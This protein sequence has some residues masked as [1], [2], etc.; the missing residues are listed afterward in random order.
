MCHTICQRDRA[1]FYH[2]ILRLTRPHPCV[3]EA[4]RLLRP[5]HLRLHEQVRRWVSITMPKCRRDPGDFNLDITVNQH[6]ENVC[7]AVIF[8][9]EFQKHLKILKR[10]PT[11]SNKNKNPHESSWKNNQKVIQEK[12]FT[13]DPTL[14][15][16]PLF[17]CP[18][19]GRPSQSSANQDGG[20]SSVT[21][22]VVECRLHIHVSAEC[23]WTTGRHP[24]KYQTEIKKSPVFVGKKLES[25]VKSKIF[26]IA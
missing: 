16:V 12:H 9:C 4:D 13:C 14:Q 1:I 2:G 17:F 24:T 6:V 5:F 22:H 8:F 10:F 19:V 7:Q 21:A 11:I 23:S 3:S 18:L 26:G 20:S 15:F 25:Y